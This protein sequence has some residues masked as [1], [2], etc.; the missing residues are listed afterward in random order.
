M[1]DISRARDEFLDAADRFP[2]AFRR[3]LAGGASR[4]GFLAAGVGLGAAGVLGACATKTKAA[5]SGSGSGSGAASGSSSA[6]PSEGKLGADKSDSEKVVNFS[7]W[8]S[9][10]DVDP[11]D[12]N[13]RPTLDT[14]K[15]ET[16]IT[17]NYTE[18][19]NSNDDF[20]AKIH[21]Q[22]AAGQDT[23]RDLMV[24]SDWMIGKLR[25][26]GYLEPLNLANIPNFKDLLP[27][28]ANPAYD[29][30]RKHTVP[31]ALG[32][33]LMGVNLKSAGLTADQAQKLSIKDMMT[34]AKY[35]GKVGYFA[36]MEDGVGFGLLAT[37]ADPA[38]FTDDQF[39]AAVAYV[40]KARDNNQIRQFTGNDYINDLTS[41]NYAMCM[42]YSGDIAQIDD[43]NIVWVVPAEG[44]LWFAD[45]MCIPAM[46]AHK[47]NAE[48]FMNY[49]L[50]PK[51][52]AALDDYISY[53]PSMQGADTA[54]ADVDKDALQ[55]QLI[56]PDAATKAKAHEFQNLD[57]KTLDKYVSQFK[58]VTG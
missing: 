54:M 50:E 38:K 33:T 55:N 17:V 1:N 40:Q 18:D 52:G 46:A 51:V 44:M 36:E 25:Q 49:M 15:S 23:G 26:M 2:E 47:T 5:S 4:R 37:G 39:G 34:D 7:N 32:F 19:V 8:V 10:I 14:F 28:A 12:K 9:Y 16:G 21:Q 3:R 53:I 22:L 27:E 57:L 13:K 20:F 56:F 45:N 30:N 24:L 11:D 35:K 48:K 31:W 43:P 6:A 42:A 58:D 29:P 41:G